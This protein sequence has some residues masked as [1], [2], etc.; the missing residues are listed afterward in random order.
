MARAYLSELVTDHPQSSFRAQA[1]DDLK[2]LGV[3]KPK[4]VSN[5]P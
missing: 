1:E 2:T 3:A 4:T 5:R